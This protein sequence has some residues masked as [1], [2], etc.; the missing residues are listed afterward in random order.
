MINLYIYIYIYTIV[1]LYTLQGSSDSKES[2]CNARDVGSI[3]GLGRSLGEV[4]GYPFQSSR[5][6]NSMDRGTWQAI[7]HGVAKSQA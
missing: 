4:N 1:S 3:P 6:E 5:L 7:V 2:S